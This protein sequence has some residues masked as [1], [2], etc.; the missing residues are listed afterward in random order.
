MLCPECGFNNLDYLKK[1]VRCGKLLRAPELP[2]IDPH[3][4]RAKGADRARRLLWRMRR[5]RG[6]RWRESNGEAVVTPER[7]WTVADWLAVLLLPGFGQLR[8]GRLLF[9]IVCLAA[10]SGG[11]CGMLRAGTESVRLRMML[12]A[13]AAYG[14]SLCD[15][16][17]GDRIQPFFS[18]NISPHG[19]DFSF[20]DVVSRAV[21]G[22][23]SALIP[24]YYQFYRK[25]IVRGFVYIG[26]WLLGLSLA[27][28]YLGTDWFPWMLALAALGPTLSICDIFRFESHPYRQRLFYTVVLSLF[29][30]Q[31]YNLSYGFAADRVIGRL[32]YLVIAPLYRGP[33]LYG[34][35][36]V[37]LDREMRELRPGDLVQVEIRRYVYG[38]DNVVDRL[39][40]GPGQKVGIRN[41]RLFVDDAPAAVLPLNPDYRLP[42]LP[43]TVL[44][45]V[46][47]LLYPSVTQRGN[48]GWNRDYAIIGRGAIAARLE[49]VVF[50]FWRRRPLGLAPEAEYIPTD[51]N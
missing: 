51:S 42:D 27:V 14:V 43:E 26:I 23:P 11:L 18:T 48:V 20:R 1:C 45:S 44:G 9:G 5:R 4:P 46:E 7:E 25:R 39:L 35:E 17:F 50:P 8:R 6:F 29:V 12:I 2:A 30:Y 41:G 15:A 49:R 28:A 32:D 34:G 36:W 31:A 24:G 47:F 33:E 38:A 13:L 22:I 16:L 40:A 10:W 37:A 21:L 3:P 19:R